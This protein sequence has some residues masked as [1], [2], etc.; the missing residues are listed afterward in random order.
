MLNDKKLERILASLIDEEDR[1][2]LILARILPFFS[3]VSWDIPDIPIKLLNIC[4]KI[5]N[6]QKT[7]ILPGYYSEFAEKK[8]FQVDSSKPNTGALAEAAL[9]DSSF[10]RTELPFSNYLIYGPKPRRFLEQQTHISWGKNSILDKMLKLNTRVIL[11][12]ISEINFGWV[13]SHL[14]EYN[15]NVSYRH[16]KEFNGFIEYKTGEK[17]PVKETLFVTTREFD[18]EYDYTELNKQLMADNKVKAI[19]DGSLTIKSALAKDIFKKSNEMLSEDE[20]A[21]LKKTVA[22]KNWVNSQSF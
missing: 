19:K 14:S 7:L 1:C 17:K 12:G 18:V 21:H 6:N 16:P 11:I 8:L 13:F 15:K 22:F 2:I 20:F 3:R 9:S 5:A 10:T 4:K